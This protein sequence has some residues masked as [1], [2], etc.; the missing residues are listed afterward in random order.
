[1]KNEVV[2]RLELKERM[3]LTK[4]ENFLKWLNKKQGRFT[5]REAME[6][7]GASRSAVT[8]IIRLDLTS[9]GMVKKHAPSQQTIFYTKTDRWNLQKAIQTTKDRLHEKW[10]DEKARKQRQRRQKRG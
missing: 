8:M 7:T 6:K 2:T 10:L 5:I 4:Y 1:M 9:Q 3:L